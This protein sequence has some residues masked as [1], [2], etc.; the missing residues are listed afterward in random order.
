MY[1]GVPG[2]AK[3][4]SA[5]KEIVLSAGTF[6]TPPILLH[7]GVGD[8]A[9]LTPFGITP[10]HQLPSVGKNLTDHLL[11]GT[12]WFANSTDTYETVKR[13]TTLQGE[14]LE[15]W[16]QTGTGAYVNAGIDHVGCIRIAPDSSI[17]QTVPDP[18]GPN[19]GHFE[20]YITVRLTPL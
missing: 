1:T 3:S 12:A 20:F 14:L 15:Q 5:T 2:A 18:A 17:F 9:D 8:A 7:S 19:T 16:Q 13:N 10:V 4:V 6:G 11:I